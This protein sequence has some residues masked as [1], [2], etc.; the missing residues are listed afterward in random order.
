MVVQTMHTFPLTRKRHTPAFLLLAALVL[1]AHTV[2]AVHSTA[3]IL[4]VAD[5]CELAQY[6]PT[7]SCALPDILIIPFVHADPHLFISVDNFFVFPSVPAYFSIR[8]PP[9]LA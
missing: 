9:V 6:A 5:H 1:F 3:H 2:F 7:Q 8:A 4:V